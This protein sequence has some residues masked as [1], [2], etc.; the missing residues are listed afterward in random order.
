M[1]FGICVFVGFGVWRDRCGHWPDLS[2]TVY[3]LSLIQSVFSLIF[4]FSSGSS[5]LQHFSIGSLLF[6]TLSLPWVPAS[7]SSFSSLMWSLSPALSF[8]DRFLDTV[9]A[10]FC[11]SSLLLLPHLVWTA[12]SLGRPSMSTPSRSSSFFDVHFIFF[13]IERHAHGCSHS[14]TPS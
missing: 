10:T 11:W 6:Q 1:K 2:P 12:A 5:F 8:L 7:H 14:L 13:S 3:S 4:L 9:Q